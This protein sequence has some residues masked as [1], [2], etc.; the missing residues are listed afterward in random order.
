M[1]TPQAAAT[2][3]V[4]TQ[5]VRRNKNDKIV[6]TSN[7]PCQAQKPSRNP[8]SLPDLPFAPQPTYEQIARLEDELELSRMENLRLEE[9]LAR[10][11]RQRDDARAEL[12]RR[13]SP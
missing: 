13:G 1:S 2:R 10:A 5:K 3:G 4:S 12:R 9:A 11:L 8:V 7:R 6:L